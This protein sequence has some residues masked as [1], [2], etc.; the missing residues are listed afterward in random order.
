[1]LLFLVSWIL[2]ISLLSFALSASLF[3]ALAGFPIVGPLLALGLYDKSRRLEAGEPFSLRTMLL[4]RAKSS[5]QV[6]FAGVMLLLLMLLWMRAAVI[7]YALCF[8]LPPFEG[9]G[10]TLPSARHLRGLGAS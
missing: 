4:V 3:S 6:F 2:V 5:T 8:G 9:L 10:E 7:L 1:M